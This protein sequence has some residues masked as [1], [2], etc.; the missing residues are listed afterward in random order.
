M[1]T[2]LYR[3]QPAV[4]AD[5]LLATSGVGFVYALSDTSYT[6]P[7]VVTFL[8]GSTG[9]EIQISPLGVMPAFSVED[10]PEVV[11]AS[12][13]ILITLASLTGIVSATTTAAAAAVAAKDAAEAAAAA[14]QSPLPGGGS[15]GMVLK[16]GAAE[17]TGYWDTVAGGADDASL[18]SIVNDPSSTFRAA[19]LALAGGDVSQEDV[20]AVRK[21][22]SGGTGAWQPADRQ[23]FAG[24][25]WVGT[26][27]SSAEQAAG[28]IRIVTEA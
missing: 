8:D 7:L 24:I 18:T 22:T 14:T 9:T 26:D 5:G 25:I 23:N 1:A 11:W 19:I 16:R 3:P 10:Q 15:P 2:Y 21:R 28:D 12:G 6:T 4:S 27:P 20:F 17:R 13:D